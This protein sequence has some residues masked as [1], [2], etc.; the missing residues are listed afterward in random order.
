[1]RRILILLLCAMLPLCSGCNESIEEVDMDLITDGEEVECGGVSDNSDPNASKTIQ[2]DKLQS[3]YLKFEAD[4]PISVPITEDT[5]AAVYPS[6][7]YE[8][9]MAKEKGRVLVH[10][11]F[12]GEVFDF[13]AEEEALKRFDKVLKENNVAAMN[14]HSQRNS[15]LGTYID[16]N[17]VYEDG[18]SITVYAEGGASVIPN[19][20]DD[21]IYVGFFDGLMEECT[22]T[23]IAGTLV[24]DMSDPDA[25][26]EFTSTKI[27][28][29][30]VEFNTDVS[31]SR[32][33][34]YPY[35]RY[36]LQLR[37]D[38]LAYTY[39]DKNCALWR[40]FDV[41][42]QFDAGDEDFKAFQDWITERNLQAANGWDKKSTV[43]PSLSLQFHIY[44]ESGET[45]SIEAQGESAMPATWDTVA[46]LDLVRSLANAHNMDIM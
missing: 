35:G 24:E 34:G 32:R 2:S 5:R 6:G 9:S 16:L 42:M 23:S 13:D 4:M 46:F 44:Y 15:A 28:E 7:M 27:H 43:D 36:R 11:D 10:A 1:M 39:I 21:S 40:D 41:V 33:G 17:A 37:R 20:W 22:G 29:I 19:Y 25:P 8:F 18:E 12:A 31:P 26:K 38:G 30:Y 45:L 3:F 14:G